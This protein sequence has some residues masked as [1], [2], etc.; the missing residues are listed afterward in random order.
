MLVPPAPI[1][2]PC[3][4][5][6]KELLAACESALVKDTDVM[7]VDAGVEVAIEEVVTPVVLGVTVI[8]GDV[9]D[10]TITL[11]GSSK[12]ELELIVGS[13]GLVD[14]VV[15]VEELIIENIVGVV[16]SEVLDEELVSMTR[17]EG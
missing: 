1:P 10:D 7:L 2:T 13:T 4:R 14:I 3:D 6:V 12:L 11:P 15:S 17:K 16:M 5:V 8:S 9:L